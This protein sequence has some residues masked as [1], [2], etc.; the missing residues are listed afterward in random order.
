VDVAAGPSY[1]D[2]A[3]TSSQQLNKEPLFVVLYVVS[4]TN[5]TGTSDKKMLITLM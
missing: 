3:G 1:S 4:I 2:I 5:T